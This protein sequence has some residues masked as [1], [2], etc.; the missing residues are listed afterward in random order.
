MCS[1]ENYQNDAIDVIQT[2][3]EALIHLKSHLPTV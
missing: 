1:K 2:E 3:I